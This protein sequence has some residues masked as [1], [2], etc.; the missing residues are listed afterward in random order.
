MSQRNLRN[1]INCNKKGAAR[2]AD[3]MSKIKN[4]KKSLQDTATYPSENDINISN[5][6]LC[7]IVCIT[8]ISPQASSKNFLCSQIYATARLTSETLKNLIRG[9]LLLQTRSTAFSQRRIKNQHDHE[10]LKEPLQ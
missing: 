10:A 4:H 6:T 3:E 7:K 1:N 2:V 5:N 9:L 8:Y